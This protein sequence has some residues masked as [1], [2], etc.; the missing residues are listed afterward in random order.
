MHRLSIDS[1]LSFLIVCCH[2]AFITSVCQTP[3]TRHQLHFIAF[4]RL[5][6]EDTETHLV[7]R[8]GRGR[9]SDQDIE[10]VG[11]QLCLRVQGQR[12]KRRG[13]AGTD[14]P[15]LPLPQTIELVKGLPASLC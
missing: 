6:K 11:H 7:Q 4:K 12:E 1:A 2:S 15:H 3:K 10:K 8:E 13:C 14:H 5:I 9:H